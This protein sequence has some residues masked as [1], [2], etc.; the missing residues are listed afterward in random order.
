MDNSKYYKNLIFKVVY[1][2]V[3]VFLFFMLVLG[4]N[5]WT[6][7]LIISVF[8]TTAFCFL[9]GFIPF[10]ISNSYKPK[11]KFSLLIIA[12]VGV[13]TSILLSIVIYNNIPELSRVL[14]V[15]MFVSAFLAV[16]YLVCDYDNKNFTFLKFDINVSYFKLVMLIASAFL[17][18]LFVLDSLVVSDSWAGVSWYGVIIGTGFML[19]IAIFVGLAHTRNIKED[20]VFDLIIFIFPLSIVGARLYY[21]LFSLDKFDW[22]FIEILQVWNGGLAIYGGIIGGVIGLVI[23][24]L[25]KKQNILKVMDLAAPGLILGQAIGRWG[26]FINQEAYGSKVV[27][28]ALKWFPYAV[29]IEDKGSW[30]MATFFYESVLS[31]IVFFVLLYVVRKFKTPGITVPCYFVLYGLERVII[32]GFRTDSLYV[33]ST[34]IRVSQLLSGILIIAGVIWLTVLY[35]KHR[36][37]NTSNEKN[38]KV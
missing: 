21:V 33:A 9:G 16:N 7:D 11:Y 13:V 17:G 31:F 12:V 15:I 28:D 25:I 18:I 34:N 20:L 32:E 22:T 3:A 4:Q 8:T 6:N 2:Y 38:N 10:T 30:F 35:L 27:N 26:N 19:A 23:C 14:K 5:N 29:Y 1:I 24:C 36:V 37:N